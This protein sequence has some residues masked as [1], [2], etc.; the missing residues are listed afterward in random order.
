MASLAHYLFWITFVVVVV[1]SVSVLFCVFPAYWRSHTRAFLYLAFAFMLS[2]FDAV[3]DHTVALW[4]VPRQQ[5]FAY[6][7]L[8]RLVGLTG[9]ILLAAG[10]VSLTR[11]HFSGTTRH[12]RTTP[13]A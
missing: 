9:W 5:Y 13:S 8:R 12:D 10:V 3:A 6:I 11:L 2:I 1:T 7:V 4:H